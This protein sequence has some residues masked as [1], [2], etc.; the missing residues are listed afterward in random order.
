MDKSEIQ[1]KLTEMIAEELLMD[2]GEISIG[3]SFS[4]DLDMDNTQFLGFMTDIEN[5]FNIIF[6]DSEIDKIWCGGN[7]SDLISLIMQC[8][9]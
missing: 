6:T 7:M 4:G 1:L 8:K 9:D 2:I 5:K 3:D